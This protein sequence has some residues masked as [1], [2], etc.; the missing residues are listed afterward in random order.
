MTENMTAKR[1]AA[2]DMLTDPLRV[3]VVDDE[4][5]VAD[6][7]RHLIEAAGHL[8]EIAGSCKEALRILS[9][10]S[11]DLAFLD[12]QLPDGNGTELIGRVKAFSPDTD[13]VAMT[14]GVSR[15]QEIEIREHRVIF[16]LIKPFTLQEVQSIIEHAARRRTPTAG[17]P[18][19]TF[20]HH[21]KTRP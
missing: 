7:F 14:G 20:F 19:S 13:I 16:F 18:G 11:F 21:E 12:V 3:L 15:E 6:L 2:R 9:E 8:V 17:H 10:G 5:L 4:K 1:D